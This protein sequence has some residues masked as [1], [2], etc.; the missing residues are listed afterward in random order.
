MPAARRAGPVIELAS[1]TRQFVITERDPGIRGAVRALLRPKRRIFTAVSDVSFEVGGGET[2]A[3]LGQN[4]AGKSTLIK[5]LAGALVPTSGELRVAGR[6]PHRN[7]TANAS[8]IGVV[9]GHRTQLWWDLPVRD[10]FDILGDIYGVPVAERARRLAA[11]DAVLETAELYD[12]PV[13]HLSLGQRVRCDLAAALLHDPEVLLLDEPTIGLDVG[14]KEQV[15]RLLR[16]QTAAGKT[17]VLTTHDMNEVD[18]LCERVVLIRRGAVG[19]DGPLEELRRKYGGQGSVVVEFGSPV[20]ALR[21]ASA[22]AEWSGEGRARLVP[23]AGSSTDDV[24]LEVVQRYPVS[25]VSVERGDLEQVVRNAYLDG[26]IS[27][28]GPAAGG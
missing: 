12:K 1:V 26:A 24:L 21:L 3:L 14:V 28:V 19:F 7:R 23:A 5:M 25:A 10:S 4:G 6:A 20:P 15:R 27:G 22:V 13:R 16:T 2:V 11:F 17:I 9:F 8:R 18:R